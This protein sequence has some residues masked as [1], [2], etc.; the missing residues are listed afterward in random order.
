MINLNLTNQFLINHRL[1]NHIYIQIQHI[2][3]L[4]QIHVAHHHF[5]QYNYLHFPQLNFGLV[6]YSK[7]YYPLKSEIY[8]QIRL[9]MLK[10]MDN[11]H[12]F[13]PIENKIR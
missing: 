8:L 13:V 6:K 10:L 7:P 1:K 9:H 11:F 2:N 4:N 3:K 5:Q 12:F